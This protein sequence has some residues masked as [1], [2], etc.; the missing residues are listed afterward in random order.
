MIFWVILALMTG[1]AIF[2]VIWPLARSGRAASSGSE[3]EVYRDQLDELERDLAA[4]SIEKTEAEA[5]RIEV[6]RRLL[7]AVDAAKAV[8]IT[9]ASTST[10]IVS[11]RNR[12][13]RVARAPRW[14]WQ[15]LSSPGLAGACV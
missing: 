10:S 14:G 12:S 8:S 3:V 9:A 5:A 11:A 1:A 2:A 6:S 15:S 13:G 4:G 7:A